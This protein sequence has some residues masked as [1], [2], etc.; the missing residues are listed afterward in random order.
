MY[1]CLILMCNFREMDTEFLWNVLLVSEMSVN[2]EI[3]IQLN[4]N[5]NYVIK[6]LR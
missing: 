2:F 6:L 4:Y 1:F 5:L 3:M